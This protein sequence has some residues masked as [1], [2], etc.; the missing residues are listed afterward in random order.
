MLSGIT[1]KIVNIYGQVLQGRKQARLVLLQELVMLKDQLIFLLAAPWD[2]RIDE[3]FFRLGTWE[4]PFIL[5]LAADRLFRFDRLT[6]FYFS[7]N[8]FMHS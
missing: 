2:H 4:Q 5:L 3:K 8:T 1:G 6:D 7:G